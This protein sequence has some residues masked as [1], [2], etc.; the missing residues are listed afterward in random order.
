MKR[1]MK[2]TSASDVSVRREGRGDPAGPARGNGL[3]CVGAGAAELR[4]VRGH[5][6]APWR[7]GGGSAGP[8]RC[9][10]CCS[11]GLKEQDVIISINGQSVGSASDVSDLIRKEGALHMVVRRGNE[12]V[13]L[14]VVPEEIDP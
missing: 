12:D 6:P 9:P 3:W 11:G 2:M 7:S 5:V 10:P 13:M 8:S 4:A 1:R 14:T